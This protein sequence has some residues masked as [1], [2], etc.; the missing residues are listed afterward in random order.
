MSQKRPAM[1]GASSGDINQYAS[2]M[3]RNASS[4][5]HPASSMN[6]QDSR[7][8]QHQSSRKLVFSNSSVASSGPIDEESGYNDSE[9]TSGESANIDSSWPS[10]IPSVGEALAPF[11]SSTQL[12]VPT[13]TYDNPLTFSA[14]EGGDDD[15]PTAQF[16]PDR[17]A[18][19][20]PQQ[21]TPRQA[22]APLQGARRGV[23]GTPARFA[24]ELDPQRQAFWMSGDPGGQQ[25]DALPSAAQEA[26]QPMHAAHQQGVGGLPVINEVPGMQV[27]PYNETAGMMP[28]EMS[29]NMPGVLGVVEDSGALAIRPENGENRQETW[30][31]HN[32]EYFVASESANRRRKQPPSDADQ[33]AQHDSLH[34]SATYSS[35]QP[36]S[37]ECAT[38]REDS[39][40]CVPYFMFVHHNL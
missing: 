24:G 10:S 33:H 15:T 38:S 22:R 30:R 31:K 18:A 32:S 35:P 2:S 6:H 7:M 9:S 8:H 25:M 29:E 23:G 3:N 4:M 16:V 26:P 21:Q 17:P 20:V 39:A 40:Q 27:F 12:D 28:Y 14:L 36:S 5:H 11:A 19:S 37:G 34:K 13:N 1:G